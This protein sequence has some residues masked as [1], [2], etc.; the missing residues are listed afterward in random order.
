VHDYVGWIRFRLAEVPAQA[1]L[2]SAAI[3][4]TLEEPG[5]GPPPLAIIHCTNDAWNIDDLSID[6]PEVLPRGP[7]VSAPLGPA[8]RGRKSYPL[9]VD[10]YGKLWTADLG[11][12]AVTL[13]MVSTTPLDEPETWS[14]FYG[15]DPAESAP[16]L[17]LTTCE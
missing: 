3:T 5:M 4:L 15:L 1:K 14:N 12:N 6:K 10:L 13:G 9:D 8:V 17:E 7:R 16:V 2:V 11:D